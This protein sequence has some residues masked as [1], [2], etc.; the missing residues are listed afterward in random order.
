MHTWGP[1]KKTKEMTVQIVKSK[2]GEE[3]QAQILTEK[4]V[5]PLLDKLLTGESVKSIMKV[6]FKDEPK[7]INVQLYA[8]P[9]CNKSFK[10]EK[11]MKAHNTRAHKP[12]IP[13]KKE[14]EVNLSKPKEHPAACLNTIGDK[15]V[16]KC[17]ECEFKSVNKSKLKKHTKNKHSG[18]SESKSPERKKPRV[19]LDLSKAIV[20]ELLNG[21]HDKYETEEETDKEL[22]KLETVSFE[23]KRCDEQIMDTKAESQR[24]S[25]QNDEKILKK[26]EEDDKNNQ[27]T[28]NE[29]ARNLLILKSKEGPKRKREASHRL[30]KKVSPAQ[31]ADLPKGFRPIPAKLRKHFPNNH[32]ILMVKPDGLCGMSCGAG[33]IFAQPHKGKQFRREINKHMV[34]NWSFYQDKINF[35]YE[36]QVGVIGKNVK[37]SDP[38]EFQNFLQSSAADNLWADAEEIQAMCNMYRMSATVVKVSHDDD[39]HPT[40]NHVGPD[41]DIQKLNL[42]NTSLIGPNQVP[43]MLLLLQGAHY[44]LAVPRESIKEKYVDHPC[45]S[46]E[47]EGY[48]AEEEENENYLKKTPK[49][50]VEKFEELEIKYSNLKE[51]YQKAMAKIKSLKLKIKKDNSESSDDENETTDDDN[52]AKLKSQG[53]KR[54]SPQSKPEIEFQCGVCKKNIQQ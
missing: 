20:E 40:I 41:T 31:S 14:M 10:S 12:I 49:T 39:E 50:Q 47:E 16:L 18:S 35:P 9:T 17:A 52:I 33:H 1:N 19:A 45:D 28:Q 27:E 15:T 3:M 48:M 53:F 7:Q 11:T 46:G 34:A 8:C 24:L 29:T 43:T 30:K 4:V 22:K 37:F 26:R 6:F 32:V 13:H 36:R 44:E 38:F 51:D 23:E 54:T 2:K 5:K 21:I 25:N 42:S